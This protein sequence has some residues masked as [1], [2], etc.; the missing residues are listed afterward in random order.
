[1]PIPF[2]LPEYHHIIPL[3]GDTA[4]TAPTRVLKSLKSRPL[5]EYGE[6]QLKIIFIREDT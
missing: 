5:Q 3:N 2:A 1:M 4:H 6:I